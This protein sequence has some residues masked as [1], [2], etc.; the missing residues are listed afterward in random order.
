[1]KAW[2]RLLR[3]SLAPTAAAD[4]AAG[5]AAGAG[6]WPW[7]GRACGAILLLILASLCVYHGGMALNDWAD[8]EGDRALRPDRPI[9]SGAVRPRSALVAGLAL[10]L[11][12]PALAACVSTS[13][14]AVLLG[15]SV[16]ACAYD[17]RLRGATVGPLLL[18]SCRGGNLSAGIL[19]GAGSQLEP[20]MLAPAA[21]YAAYV[22]AVSSLG[23]LEDAPEA[24]LRSARPS[25]QLSASALIL[26]ASPLSALAFRSN[27]PAGLIAALVL[28]LAGAAGLFHRAQ[29]RGPWSGAEVTR[30]TGLG[31]RR[32]LV[33]TS[34]LSLAAA[35]RDGAIVAAAILAGYPVSY[36]LRGVFPP[37]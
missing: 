32:L 24:V 25:A 17:L 23:R 21:A 19:F 12:G 4:I 29:H 3:L 1:M 11:L 8:G 26:A 15:V 28:A 22:L 30:A 6:S 10:L 27:R 16:L 36:F 31:L 9:P 37:S 18:A 7:C 34:A 2:G 20:G 33:F 35:G 14:A 5:A 13:S